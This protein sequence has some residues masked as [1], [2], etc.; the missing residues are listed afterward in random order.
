[1]RPA[2]F[3]STLGSVSISLE[4]GFEFRVDL[5]EGF[6][7]ARLEMLRQCAAIAADDDL[8]CFAVGESVLVRADA[9]KGVVDVDEM[10]QMRRA[11]DLVSTKA[12]RVTTS[13]PVFVMA[14]GDLTR[15]AK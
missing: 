9:A 15:H 2:P 6:Y 14:Q 7:Q 8:R 10:D 1:M 5:L 3:G 4:D 11:G 12:Q 13:I